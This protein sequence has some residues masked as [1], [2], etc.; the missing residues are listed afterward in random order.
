M[1]YLSPNNI[2]MIHVRIGKRPGEQSKKQTRKTVISDII[3]MV[4]TLQPLLIMFSN[5]SSYCAI[6]DQA[7]TLIISDILVTLLYYCIF[8]V[9]IH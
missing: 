4:M 8:F 1:L 9:E 3:I 2:Q 5:L 6:L 7:A